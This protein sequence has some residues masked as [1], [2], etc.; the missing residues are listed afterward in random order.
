MTA[1]AFLSAELSARWEDDFR[2][3]QNCLYLSVSPWS[4]NA[5]TREVSWC[6]SSVFLSHSR[7][8]QLPSASALLYLTHAVRSIPVAGEK[9]FQKVGRMMPRLYRE[10][11]WEQGLGLGFGIWPVSAQGQLRERCGPG[12]VNSTLPNADSLFQSLEWFCPRLASGPKNNS[13]WPH[14]FSSTEAA[15]APAEEK[16]IP[17]APPAHISICLQFR[18]W[19]G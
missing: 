19:T 11:E 2:K 5:P 1:S 18:E 17:L 7:E 8:L 14:L 10:H 12:P 6:R 13:P 15:D 3:E 9:R 4:T 16:F